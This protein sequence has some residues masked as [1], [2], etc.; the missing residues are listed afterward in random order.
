MKYSKLFSLSLGAIFLASCNIGDNSA[1]LQ[2]PQN[3]KAFTTSYEKF[4]TQET[5]QVDLNLYSSIFI[6]PNQTYKYQIIGQNGELA[7]GN[8]SGTFTCNDASHC[9]IPSIILNKNMIYYISIL[10]DDGSFVGGDVI[11]LKNAATYLD[12]VIDDT[13]TSNYISQKIQQGLNNPFIASQVD[14]K[15]FKDAMDYKPDTKLSE[16]VYAYY[17]FL[18]ERSNN[19]ED[20]ILTMTKQYQECADKNICSLEPSFIKNKQVVVDA[21]NSAN[22]A[23]DKYARDKKDATLYTSYK[24]FKDNVKDKF[25]G[26]KD[27]IS[28][29]INIFFAGAGDKI[30]S[31]ASEV[32]TAIDKGFNIIGIDNS[33]AAYTR[34]ELFNNNLAKYYSAATPNYA[35][36]ST[37][38]GAELLS[39]QIRRDFLFRNNYAVSTKMIVNNNLGDADIVNYI[40]NNDNKLAFEWLSKVWSLENVSSRKENI[41]Y[42]SDRQNIVALAKAYQQIIQVNRVAGINNISK[43][44]QYNQLLIANMQDGISALQSSMYL[45]Y[46]S[47][48]LRDQKNNFKGEIDPTQITVATI[49]LSGDYDIDISRLRNYYSIKLNN[50]K[51]AYQSVILAEKEWV[52]ANVIQT[53]QFDGKCNIIATDG[54]NYITAVCPYN[55]QESGVLRTKYITSTLNKSD[56]KCFTTNKDASG[57]IMS[58]ADV[59]NIGGVLQCLNAFPLNDNSAENSKYLVETS[60]LTTSADNDNSWYWNNGNYFNQRF[61]QNGVPM[62]YSFLSNPDGE[63]KFQSTGTKKTIAKTLDLSDTKL[64]NFDKSGLFSN[65]R[66]YSTFT[67]FIRDN[68]DNLI[69]GFSF[70]DTTMKYVFRGDTRGLSIKPLYANAEYEKNTWVMGEGFIEADSVLNKKYRIEVMGVS[71]PNVNTHDSSSYDVNWMFVGANPDAS[72]QIRL[73]NGTWMKSCNVVPD[74]SLSNGYWLIANCINSKGEHKVNVVGSKVSSLKSCWIENNSLKCDV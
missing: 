39:L 51:M 6:S 60:S 21:L 13:S 52:A 61:K 22:I 41:E 37:Q 67:T 53:V 31:G 68:N 36:I 19:S 38:I 64:K 11:Y 1:K 17:Y 56:S 43:R 24:W 32:F 5:L 10:D 12:I 3:Y 55:Y 7:F 23:I 70:N 30:V 66:N 25:P 73:P 18:K 34:M 47:V 74:S 29:G 45:D 35:E 14:T 48:L 2:A 9:M 33:K 49:M 59:Q 54:L 58:I 69:G 57:D 40:N 20:P 50:L 42:I 27:L 8:N 28:G 71:L 4:S 44:N 65:V 16:L 46:L 62:L 15:L 26:V 63:F 72:N